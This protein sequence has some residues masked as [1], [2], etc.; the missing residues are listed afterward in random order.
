MM[1]LLRKRQFPVVGDGAGIWSFLHV[2]GAA[3]ANVCALERGESGVYNLCDDDP[4]PVAVWLPELARDV[5][6]PPPL[7]IPTWLARLAIGEVGVSM[8]TRIRGMS[9]EKAKQELGWT[10]RWRSWR[11]GFREG[12]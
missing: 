4:A 7:R 9:N 12:L 10:P 3:S 2:D 8:M 6:A 5:G 1:D 11:E